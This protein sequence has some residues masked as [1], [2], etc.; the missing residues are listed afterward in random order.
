MGYQRNSN[1]YTHIFDHARLNCD[2]TNSSRRLPTSG[3]QYGEQL[4][5][6]TLTSFE[7]LQ[8]IEMHDDQHR[9]TSK[10]VLGPIYFRHE[11]FEGI[12]QI[13]IS[14]EIIPI[15]KQINVA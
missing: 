12:H 13:V 10:L 3:V 1:G 4:T 6:S 15:Q 8:D 11:A 9:I 14:M 2:I 7:E 5:E